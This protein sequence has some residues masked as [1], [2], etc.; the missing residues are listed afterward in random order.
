M[1]LNAFTYQYVEKYQFSPFWNYFF[2][3]W[4]TCI[5]KQITLRV[6]VPLA[7]WYPYINMS[8]FTIGYAYRLM[9]H[10]NI[11]YLLNIKSFE[12][13][14]KVLKSLRYLGYGALYFTFLELIFTDRKPYLCHTG[15]LLKLMLSRPALLSTCKYL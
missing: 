4:F 1:L 12:K 2:L 10:P 7:L 9:T 8:S 15:W 13:V 6:F 14:L 11:R 5:F 3:F